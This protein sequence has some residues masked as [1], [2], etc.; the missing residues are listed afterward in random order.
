MA[1]TLKARLTTQNQIMTSR[2]WHTHLTQ[3]NIP[4][5]RCEPG[6]KRS[7]PALSMGTEAQMAATAM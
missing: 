6:L 2:T 3:G 7:F 1:Q 4:S 5:E